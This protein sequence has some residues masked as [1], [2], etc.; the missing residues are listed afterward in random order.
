MKVGNTRRAVIVETKMFTAC[1]STQQFWIRNDKTIWMFKFPWAFVYFVERY[2]YWKHKRFLGFR[3]GS[4][5]WR[6]YSKRK[7]FEDER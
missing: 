3:W 5:P 4:E 2:G 1:I 6:N 7:Q